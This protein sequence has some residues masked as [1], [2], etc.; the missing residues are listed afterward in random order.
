MKVKLKN[1]LEMLKILAEREKEQERGGRRSPCGFSDIDEAEDKI[2]FA[3]M[4][5]DGDFVLFENEE[6][7]AFI[8][9]PRM[10]EVVG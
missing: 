10:V 5:K 6:E 1:K 3:L 7:I 2:Y 4:D 9:D 8:A